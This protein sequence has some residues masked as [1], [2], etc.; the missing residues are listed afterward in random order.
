MMERKL[1]S[2]SHLIKIPRMFFSDGWEYRVNLQLQMHVI[3]V[4]LETRLKN[5]CA[6]VTFRKQN[7]GRPRSSP[8]LKSSVAF[9]GFY[10]LI[11]LEF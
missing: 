10:R 1:N 11:L 7:G 3:N 4:A 6:C 2:T 8:D 5:G 9:Y